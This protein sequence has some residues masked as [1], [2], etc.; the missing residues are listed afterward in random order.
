[1]KSFQDRP[2]PA[3]TKV[4]VK[5]LSPLL[6][7]VTVMASKG[8]GRVWSFNV[9][10]WFLVGIVT[11]LVLYF[12]FSFILLAQYFGEQHQENLLVKLEKRF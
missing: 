9:N 3:K 10:F 1:M 8:L 5:N 11:V 2:L 4:R 6:N 7:N 12:L